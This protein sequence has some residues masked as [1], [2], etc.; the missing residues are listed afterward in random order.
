MRRWFTVAALSFSLACSAWAQSP[1]SQAAGYTLVWKDTFST[2]SY[3][4][5]N[6]VGYNWYNPGVWWKSAGGVVTNPSSTY[7]NLNWQTG[8]RGTATEISTIA[9]NASYFHAWTFGYFEI[10]MKFN[11][12]TGSFPAL[13]LLTPAFLTNIP[14]DNKLYPELDMFEW[15]SQT[16][17]TF[18]GTL[19]IWQN[20]VDVGSNLPNDHWTVPAGTD[21][22]NF[23]TYGVLWTPKTISWYINDVLLGSFDITSP[24][25][26]TAFGGANPLFIIL[27]QQTGCNW[28]ATCPGQVSPLSMQVQWVHVYAAPVAAPVAA[29][30]HLTAIVK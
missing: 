10:S 28:T 6:D 17:T 7:V 29:P 13:W 18:Y 3:T 1:P 21:F 22:A 26:S 11:P 2:L 30:T 15:Q 14:G 4:T 23:N 8:Q 25:I 12:T 16:P 20:N 19:H 5:T 27:S 9:P 24:P